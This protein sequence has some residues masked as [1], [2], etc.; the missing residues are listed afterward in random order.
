MG[1]IMELRQIRYFLAVADARSFVNAAEKQFVS[2]QAISKS[3]AQLEEELNIELFMRDSS[4]AFLTP[5]GVMF[6]DRA[7]AVVM[8]LDNLRTQMQ[9][10]GTRYHQRIRIAFSIGTLPLLEDV[11]H[12][13]RENQNNADISFEEYPEEECRQLLM[14]HK[15]DVVVTTQEIRDPLYATELLLQSPLGILIRRQ[16]ELQDVSIHD[17]SWIPIAG[18]NDSQIQEFCKNHSI[19]L[20][21]R[22]YDLYRLFSLTKQGKCALLLP[23]CLCPEQMAELQWLPLHHG[24]SWHLYVT[25]PRSAEKNLLY[26]AALDDLQH[27]V[28]APMVEIKEDPI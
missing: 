10:Y 17:L 23:R 8:E 5:A 26:S 9:A 24:G 25:R 19:A 15:A 3:V 4:G 27:Q 14:A 11:L 1:C 13:Y 18:Q 16:E 2:R 12:T 6:Y 22:G 20:R 21:Y 28:F 7:R